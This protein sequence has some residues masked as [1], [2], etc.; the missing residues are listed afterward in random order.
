MRT[1]DTS[2]IIEIIDDDTDAFGERGRA[3]TIHDDGGPRWIGPA[4]VIVLAGL[5]A[6]G[7]ASSASSTSLPRASPVPSTTAPV[8]PTTTLPAVTTTT[9][10]APP[11]PYYA[12]ELP[13]EYTVQYAE[14]QQV[15]GGFPP[16]AGY[17]LWATEGSSSTAGSWFSVETYPG[18]GSS[19]YAIDAFR[20]QTAKH[21]IGI[22]HTPSG[23][24][25]AQ[26]TDQGESGVSL[27]SYGI[28]DDALIRLADSISVEQREI[29]LGDES[30]LDGYSLLSTVSPWFV[31]QGVPVEQI[32]YMAG[33]D[34]ASAIGVSVAPRPSS[35]SGGDSADRQTALRFFLNDATPFNIG[36]HSG[37]AGTLVGQPDYA[38]ATWTVDDHI[39]TI[40]GSMPVTDLVGIAITV[41]QVS[42]SEWNGMKFQATKHNADNNFGDYEETPLAAVSF[43][44]DAN[45]DSWK[46]DVSVASFANTQ[47]VNW[48][49]G[50]NGFGTTL[51]D[52]AGINSVVEGQRTY[53]LA[54]L[55]RSV[56]PTAHLQIARAGLDP[57]T[58]PF[59]DVGADLDRT[60]AAYAFS[61]AAPYTAQI[62]GDD[63]TVLATWPV[64]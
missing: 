22:T 28:A 9:E 60:F 21:S 23:Q 34:A 48:Q 33:N 40:S 20:V 54:D 61:E 62:V 6:Y 4:A 50:G 15:D 46:V 19:I 57:V 64:S 7:V 26:F 52:D 25:T 18:A 53:V 12:A 8:R 41:H 49:W 36:R 43:G 24:T 13:R 31:V 17:Q 47:Q 37:V 51:D 58:V 55:P 59:L 44:A 56:A 38:I 29:H 16:F 1:D 35:G 11:V 5:I 63:G 2:E 32:F 42:A 27:T 14:I 39:V 30:L 3:T 10:P 45:G